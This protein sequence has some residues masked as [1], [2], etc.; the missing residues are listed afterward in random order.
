MSGSVGF[1]AVISFTEGYSRCTASAVHVQ[2]Q[3]RPGAPN[4]RPR[5]RASGLARWVKEAEG[6]LSKAAEGAPGL[7]GGEA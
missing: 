4:G 5:T 6:V 3:T 2:T 7:L 1:G